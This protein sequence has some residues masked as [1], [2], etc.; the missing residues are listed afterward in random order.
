MKLLTRIPPRTNGTVIL[1]DESLKG[2]IIFTADPQSGELC[3]DVPGDALIARLL[4]S[5]DFEPADEADYETAERLMD[6][7]AAAAKDDGDDDESDD[8]PVKMVNDGM[9]IEAATPPVPAK[10]RP[11]R[12]R[13]TVI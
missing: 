13:R 5:G 1:R 11:G 10:K 7:A 9:P 2:P 8:L 12:P 6:V 3:A 4:A